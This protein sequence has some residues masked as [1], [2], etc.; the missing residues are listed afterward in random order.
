MKYTVEYKNEKL[1]IDTKNPKKAAQTF[2]DI[3]IEKIE[4]NPNE[5]IKIVNTMGDVF[6]IQIDKLDL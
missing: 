4:F 2:K 5:S 1:V 3:M 6:N